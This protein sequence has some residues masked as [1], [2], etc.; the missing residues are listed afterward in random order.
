MSRLRA[1][2]PSPAAIV[3][4]LAGVLL[5]ALLIAY[6]VK[7]R[8]YVTGGNGVRPLSLVGTIPQGDRLC[9]VGVEVPAGTAGIRFSLAPVERP[10]SVAVD[11]TGGDG[12]ARTSTADV[13][14]FSPVTAWFEP[15]GETT[16][17]SVC[18]RARGGDIAVAGAG[19][20]Q[21]N[22]RPLRLEGEPLNARLSMIFLPKEGSQR[23]LASQ[24]PDVMA[25]AAL[26]R[27]DFIDPGVL[28]VVMLLLLPLALVAAVV[29]I[30]RGLEGRRAAALLAAVTF[31]SAGSWSV[32][33]LPFD[34]P[35]ESEHF[36]YLQSVAETGTR[37]DSSPTERGVYATGQTAAL[38]AVR[39]PTRVGGPDQRPP[40]SE[41]ARERYLKV[42]ARGLPLNDGGGYADATRLHLPAYYSLLLPG[43][44]AAGD[45][46]LAQLTLARLISSL[47]AIVVAMCAFGIV[48]ELLPGRPDLALL[49]GLLVALHPMFSFI[50]GA[51]NN[52]MGVNAGAA[53]VAYLGVRVLRRP[54]TWCLVAF[55]AALA[56]TP[57]MKATGLAL[58]PPALI[59]LAGYVWRHPRARPAVSAVAA[60]AAAFVLVSV[61]LRAALGAAV[62]SG[63]SGST[64]GEGVVGVG[65]LGSLGG[66]LSYTWQLALPRLSF[67]N[68]HYGMA[69]PFYDIY[70][71]R[72]WGA[73][74]WYSFVFP[75]VIFTAIIASLALFLALG[76]A[77]LW[78]ARARF[79][80][81]GWEVAFLLAIPIAVIVA[82][83]FAYY[84]PSP[85]PVPGEQGRY[86]F[87]AAAP[88]AALAAGS[89]LGLPVR[90]QRFAAVVVVVSM[91]G[92]AYAGR[93]TYLTGVFT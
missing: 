41:T 32:I 40:W 43:Y 52:D 16:T 23:S 65:I 11:F 85:S 60:V 57:V 58:Y 3:A 89:L 1:V 90:W 74:G 77:K 5:L 76:V 18:I 31:V 4:I 67:M 55:G 83:S 2:S 24:W 79:S 6:A 64:E 91:A 81:W 22:D 44:F 7:P 75:K 78:K 73:F 69:W 19:E 68:E 33:T 70:I 61:A 14:A 50:G 42:V 49:A 29:G 20:I 27:P 84:T 17:G 10:S 47:L 36:A 45:D 8:A 88:L 87:T 62:A 56:V 51:V 63:A 82:I 92:L 15:L 59:V 13:P 93:L 30:V 28:W 72:G 54:S 38:E 25:R 48:R 66:K 12:A 37:P 86:L 71:V 34:S 35:D 80:A 46:V 26:F 53:L 39:H 9:A 21:S